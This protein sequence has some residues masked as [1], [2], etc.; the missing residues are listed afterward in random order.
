[1]STWASVNLVLE[2]HPGQLN[3]HGRAVLL[4][5]TGNISPTSGWPMIQARRDRVPGDHLSER[6]L[7]SVITVWRMDWDTTG[8]ADGA[9]HLPSPIQT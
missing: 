9:L 4:D 1:M 3:G 5:C 6:L 8:A 2:F 7:L